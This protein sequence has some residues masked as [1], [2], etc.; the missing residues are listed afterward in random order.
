VG[1]RSPGTKRLSTSA[2]VPRRARS[3]PETDRSRLYS[4]FTDWGRDTF[5]A[6]RGLCIANG[7]LDDA[8]EILLSWSSHVSEGMLPNRFPDSGEAPEYNSVDASLWFIIALHDL[9][10]ALETAKRRLDVADK[11]KSLSAVERF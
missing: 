1:K 10:A 4:W 9:F 2:Q 3:S 11:A 6:L 5:I 7:R 8:L